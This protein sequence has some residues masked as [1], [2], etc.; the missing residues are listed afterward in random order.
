[1]KI[2]WKTVVIVTLAA[3][4]TH[5][6]VAGHK[7]KKRFNAIKKQRDKFDALCR[8]YADELHRNQIP[9]DPFVRIAMH[10]I[11]TS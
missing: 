2:D 9:I 11:V 4:W 7:N 5:D 10:D 8:L 6:M 3:G 1:M